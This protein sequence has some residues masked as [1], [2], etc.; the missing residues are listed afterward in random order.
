MTDVTI[1]APRRWPAPA[2]RGH[3]DPAQVESGAHQAAPSVAV[4][5]VIAAPSS[6][7]VTVSG[8]K[9]PDEA[10]AQDDPDRVGQA[11]QLLEVGRDEQDR[12]AVASGPLELVP[13]RRLGADVDAAGR[14]CGDEHLGLATHLAADDELLLV[15]A[16]QRAGGH[17]DRRGADVVLA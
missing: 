4:A 14:V 12:E 11:D 7:R 6:S 17:V 16:G 10:S 5:P 13:D 15:A 1:D 2:R 8:S 9:S 3:Q